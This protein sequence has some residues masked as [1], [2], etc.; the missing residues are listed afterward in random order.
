MDDLLQDLI[1]AEEFS[2][3]AWPNS[4]VPVG[5]GVYTIWEGEEFVYVGMS[6]R[7]MDAGEIA[8]VKRSGKVKMLRQRLGSHASGRHSGDQF[9]VELRIPEM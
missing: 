2:F 4:D 3:S 5:A 9:F 8:E 1:R 7:A 6:G